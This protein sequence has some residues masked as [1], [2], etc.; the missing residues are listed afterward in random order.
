MARLSMEIGF[1]K[2]ENNYLNGPEYELDEGN[3]IQAIPVT[4]TDLAGYEVSIKIGDKVKTVVDNYGAPKRLRHF[5]DLID[6]VCRSERWVGKSEERG[7]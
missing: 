1:F 3:K 5:E 7:E 2:M 4:W 6:R